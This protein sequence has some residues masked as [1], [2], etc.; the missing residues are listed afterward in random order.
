ML[1]QQ[2]L[3]NLIVSTYALREEAAIQELIEYL[4]SVYVMWKQR[5][6][7]LV[8]T[9]LD[10]Y[11]AVRK[12]KENIDPN[13]TNILRVIPIDALTPPYVD[14]VAEKVL[15]LIDK[16]KPD[17]TFR[18]TLDGRLYRVTEGVLKRLHSREAID[19]IAKNVNRKVNLEHPDKVIYIKTLKFR[20]EDYASIT[21]C[22][23]DEIISTQ[24]MV[25]GKA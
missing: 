18:I 15:E 16:I 24:K 1:E 2:K 13:F 17:E 7:L 23:P 25:K 19:E 14:K 8:K 3:P 21:I 9:K 20:G 4:G 10:P 11:E 22:R 5:S 6:L 12:I